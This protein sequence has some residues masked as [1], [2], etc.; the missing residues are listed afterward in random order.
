MSPL[1]ATDDAGPDLAAV[2]DSTALARDGRWVP[3]FHIHPPTGLLNDPNGM[4]WHDG[5]YHL[6]HQWHPEAP[7]HGLKR[8]RYLTSTDLVHWEPQ[9]GELLPDQ[10]Y[11][12]HG[13]YSGSGIYAEGAIRLFYTGNVRGP[14]GE[15]ESYQCL[16][17]LN[18]DGT[19][20]NDAANPLLGEI[21]GY[22]ASMRDPKVWERDGSYWM[23][24][25]V[26][27]EDR[28]GNVLLLCG[29]SLREWEVVGPLLTGS[30]YGFM[31]ECP[32]LLTLEKDVLV[33]SP[34]HDRGEPDSPTRFHDE[35][36]YTVGELHYQTGKMSHGSVA[37]VDFGPD[38]YAPQTLADGQGRTVMVG[39]LGMPDQPGHPEL[40]L[41]HPT[42]EDG[43]VHILSV[44]R[45]LSLRDGKL[46][47][48]PVP[49]LS[50]AFSAPTEIPLTELAADS[51]ASLSS[52]RGSAYQLEL[53]AQ[54][55]PGAKFHI[56]LRV[57]EAAATTV[58]LDP[59]AGRAL[60]DRRAHPLGEGGLFA[61]PLRDSSEV[62]ATILVDE[63][64]LEVF[65]D[66]GA[67]VFSARIYPGPEA[68]GIAFSASGGAVSFSGSFA[69]A[70]D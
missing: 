39:W 20:S 18:A 28:R 58:T 57:G 12:S 38:F 15:R 47:Q 24:L 68:T 44:P 64:S 48:Q 19:I 63:S 7:G 35:T 29:Q 1:D 37:R 5:T 30:D 65:L 10:W 54:L 40:A 60:L 49:E 8:W 42:C 41:K 33:F 62:T 52:V 45:V 26:Q 46:I 4:V 14:A 2:G 9:P 23:V 16:A 36:V 17:T 61:G 50:A 22:T 67:T 32:D 34:Q 6:F 21:P 66:D 25:G 55:S 53:R 11:N 27:T 51:S 13:C 31:C 56:S 70:K 69:H 3:R 59:S 43:W